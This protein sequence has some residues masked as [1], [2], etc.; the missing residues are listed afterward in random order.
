[1][2]K[3]SDYK[4]ELVDIIQAMNDEHGFVAREIEISCLQICT[5]ESGDVKEVRYNVKIVS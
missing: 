4:Q 3:I 2:K 5:D 1:M